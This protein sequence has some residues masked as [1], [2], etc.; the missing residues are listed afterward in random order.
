MEIICERETIF[1]SEGL[2]GEGYRD[3]D[4][5]CGRVCCDESECDDCSFISGCLMK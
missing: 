5:H 4:W 1:L 2:A 3:C